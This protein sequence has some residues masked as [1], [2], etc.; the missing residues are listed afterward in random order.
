MDQRYQEVFDEEIASAQ[1]ALG[2]AV[3]DNNYAEAARQQAR[4]EVIEALYEKMI[5]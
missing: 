3:S 4:L 5:G 2:E 1:E